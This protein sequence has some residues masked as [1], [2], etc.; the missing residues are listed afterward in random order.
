MDLLTRLKSWFSLEGTF[1]PFLKERILVRDSSLKIFTSSVRMNR[2][3][4][5]SHRR[6]REV[7]D[8]WCVDFGL[9]MR[10]VDTKKN[11]EYFQSHPLKI[12]FLLITFLPKLGHVKRVQ[13]VIREKQKSSHLRGWTRPYSLCILC[14]LQLPITPFCVRR[15]ITPVLNNCFPDDQFNN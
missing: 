15:S 12:F 11:M 13:L 4:A 1:N 5:E 14:N 7:G 9:F 2:L 3:G 6:G 10:C 8:Y